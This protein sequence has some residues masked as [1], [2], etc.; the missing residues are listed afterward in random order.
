MSLP[1]DAIEAGENGH[2][3]YV[4][5]TR[6]RHIYNVEEEARL[7]G[8]SMDVFE[9]LA[10]EFNGEL[11]PVDEIDFDKDH[12]CVN[13]MK[14]YRGKFGH[15]SEGPRLTLEDD[16]RAAVCELLASLEPGDTVVWDKRNTP[17]PV[18]LVDEDSEDDLDVYIQ[19]V[20]SSIYRITA[21][22]NESAAFECD[23]F[24]PTLFSYQP[25]HDKARG[26]GSTK[27]E[28]GI[29]K[30]GGTVRILCRVE[31]AAETP[32]LPEVEEI[33]AFPSPSTAAADGGAGG[34]DAAENSTGP[35]WSRCLGGGD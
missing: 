21:N 24:K 25:N 6:T 31:K 26:H 11:V 15:P 7:C 14:I 19:G 9:D 1:D 12:C 16:G 18:V 13:C 33:D 35:D 17:A 4:E 28:A 34:R 23:W 32:T 8:Q 2:A 5:G 29:W 10:R 30:R 3:A 27:G 22:R 20:Q